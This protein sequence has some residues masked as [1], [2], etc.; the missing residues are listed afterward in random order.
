MYIK[1]EQES[2]HYLE[3]FYN[4]ENLSFVHHHQIILQQLKFAQSAYM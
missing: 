1:Q 3:T 4:W 2:W